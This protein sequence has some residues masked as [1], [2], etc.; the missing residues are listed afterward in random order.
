MEDNIDRDFVRRKEVLDL[1]GIPTLPAVWLRPHAH[2]SLASTAS[3]IGGQIAWPEHVPWPA[4]DSVD[5]WLD[6]GDFQNDFLVSLAQFRKDE[7]PE[8]RFPEESDILQ[9]LWCPRLHEDPDNELGM[10]GPNVKVFWHRM[11]E[12]RPTVNPAPCCAW[13][14]LVPVECALRPLH[15]DDA[16][17]WWLLTARQQASVHEYQPKARIAAPGLGWRLDPYD[18][19]L[20][21]IPGTKLLGYSTVRDELTDRTCTCGRLMAHLLEIGSH[22]VGPGSGEWYWRYDPTLSREHS[23]RAINPIGLSPLDGAVRIFYC[24]ECP[25]RPIATE[26]ISG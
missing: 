8:I 24:E 2:A 19:E 22:E 15:L 9:I 20:G 11:A 6:D 3:K 10:L 16:P 1:F 21:T 25:E 26:W 14:D 18:S 12:L 23:R 4:C 7:Y 5:M 13:K 17:P